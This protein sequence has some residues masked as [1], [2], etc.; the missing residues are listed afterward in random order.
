MV[1]GDVGPGRFIQRSGGF[2]HPLPEAFGDAVEE[3][4][5]LNLPNSVIAT[6]LRENLR[7]GFGAFHSGPID[8]ELES[9]IDFGEIARSPGRGFQNGRAAHAPVR[10]EKRSGGL[11]FADPDGGVGDGDAHEIGEPAVLDFKGEE[12][13]YGGLHRV[14]HRLDR[15]A[16]LLAPDASGGDE[17]VA[18]VVNFAGRGFDLKAL[19]DFSNFRSSAMGP[20]TGAVLTGGMGQA[21]DDG[22]RTVSHRKHPPVLFDLEFHATIFEPGYGIGSL[23]S[24]KRAH[25][26]F[27]APRIT[28]DQLARV[29]AVVGDIATSATRNSD[30]GQNLGSAFQN[31]HLGHSR[32]RSCNCGKESR[33]A[34]SDDDEVARSACVVHESLSISENSRS[35][36][37]DS[38]RK[39]AL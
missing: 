34:S 9:V 30:L 4:S 16:G 28:L 3:R 15:E 2:A 29:K 38:P 39:T 25:E 26:I 13:W 19:L 6:V 17:D 11:E 18:G 24:M 36:N 1:F 12:R 33:C 20:P 8:D 31:K 10:N 5:F 27:L 23:P 7:D 14:A 22:L 32:F 21:I 37:L 35:A